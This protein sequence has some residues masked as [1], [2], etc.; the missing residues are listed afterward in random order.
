[1]S[2]PA[3]FAD[4]SGDQRYDE[5]P[6]GYRGTPVPAPEAPALPGPRPAEDLEA[7][8]QSLTDTAQTLAALAARLRLG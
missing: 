2:L 1:M 7:A 8:V 3:A 6:I 5:G 4:F